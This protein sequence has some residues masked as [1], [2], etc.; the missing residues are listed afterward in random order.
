MDRMAAVSMLP[1]AVVGLILALTD[2]GDAIVALPM[3]LFVLDMIVAG[4]R[5]D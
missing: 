2:A 1:G 5:G 3:L 4:T